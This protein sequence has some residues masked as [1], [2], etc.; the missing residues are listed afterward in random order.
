MVNGIKLSKED[1]CPQYV[2]FSELWD[3]ASK[4]LLCCTRAA[5][6]R[7]SYS[8]P[9]HIILSYWSFKVFCIVFCKFLDLHCVSWQSKDLNINCIMWV[10]VARAQIG[11]STS[12]RKRKSCSRWWHIVDGMVKSRHRHIVLCFFSLRASVASLL[13]LSAPV[14]SAFHA[15]KED[16]FAIK[17]KETT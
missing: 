14:L 9:F 7:P 16:G 11:L 12:N 5:S 8:I 1:C 2:K 6:I 10:G 4:K 17:W 3:I 15:W 13:R